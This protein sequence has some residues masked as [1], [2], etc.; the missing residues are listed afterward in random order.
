VEPAARDV[1]CGPCSVR[2]ESHHPDVDV[3]RLERTFQGCVRKPLGTA[4]ARLSVHLLRPT[5]SEGALSLPLSIVTL[6]EKAAA[7]AF[8]SSSLQKRFLQRLSRA[9]TDA[10]VAAHI[11]ALLS[12]AEEPVLYAWQQGVFAGDGARLSGV[13]F[14]ER[15]GASVAWPA[16]VNGHGILLQ[17]VALKAGG[18]LLHGAGIA[19]NGHGW[20]FVGQSGVGKS[21]LC[22]H[23]RE[24]ALS[25]DGVLLV[26]QGRSWNVFPTPLIQ[27]P[28]RR[29]SPPHAMGHGV[30]LAALLFLGRSK[31][32]RVVVAQPAWALAELVSRHIHFLPALPQSFA[33][34]ALT[35]TR[36][37]LDTVTTGRALL[38]AHSRMEEIA[39][40]VA[41]RLW[42][43]SSERE[44]P[45]RQP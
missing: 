36:S 24:E 17:M 34:L 9:L 5:T 27:M 21:T 40:E 2:I 20:V 30:P 1:I 4:E 23:H 44:A 33:R 3:P 6:A 43:A 14:V 19:H 32:T 31:K 10:W 11:Q 37:L 35:N 41:R 15:C 29:K 45:Q 16:L 26:P 25:D 8:T 12:H 42:G 18:I 13:L 39:A 28:R 22:R 38:S 7:R